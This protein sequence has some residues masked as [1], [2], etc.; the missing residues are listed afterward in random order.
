MRAWWS[1][2]LSFRFPVASAQK[3]CVVLRVFTNTA[4]ESVTRRNGMPGLCRTVVFAASRPDTVVQ[5]LLGALARIG[6]GTNRTRSADSMG[7]M[8]HA[9]LPTYRTRGRQWP[10]PCKFTW[11]C[12]SVRQVAR[13]HTRR[14]PLVGPSN[15]EDQCRCCGIGP[16]LE[17]ALS[18]LEGALP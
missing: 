12:A 15:G 7:V 9:V 16:R 11:R 6:P 5:P 3:M 2:E 10:R 4:V 18:V 14:G 8:V 13:M 1:S 17:G